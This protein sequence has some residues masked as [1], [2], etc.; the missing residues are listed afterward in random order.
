MEIKPTTN[1]NGANGTTSDPREQIM[2]DIYVGKLANGIENAYESAIEAG[3]SEDHS[4]NITL[5]GWFKE[6]KNKLRRKDM[7]SKAERNLDKVLD[8]DMLTEEGKVNTPVAT[9]VTSVSTTVVK[10]L[11]KE[12]YSERIEQTG[13]DGKDLIPEALSQEEKDK[14]AIL[15]ND[16]TSTG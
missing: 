13:K 16:K 6:R 1:P 11:G 5:Q 10:T 14:L 3:Y 4:R 2:W 7:L 12:E 8:F 9:L 15:L